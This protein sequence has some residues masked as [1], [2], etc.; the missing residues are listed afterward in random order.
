MVLSVF[1]S[2]RTK[3]LIL[4]NRMTIVAVVLVADVITVA[5]LFFLY[6]YS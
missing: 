2:G 3:L 5:T 1:W 6:S 4:R